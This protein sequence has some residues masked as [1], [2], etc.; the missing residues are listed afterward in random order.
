MS[1]L[2]VVIAALLLGA[3]PAG[4]QQQPASPHGVLPAGLDCGACHAAS[5]WTP[6]RRPLAFDHARQASFPLEGRHADLECRGCHPGLKFDESAIAEGNCAA[7][8]VDVHRGNLSTDCEQCHTPTSFRDV[9]GVTLHARTSFPLTGA[10]LQVSCESCHRD[11]R[12]GAFAALDTDCLACH[13][14]E[15]RTAQPVDHAAAGFSTNCSECHTTLAFAQVTGFDHV[16]ASGGFELQGAHAVIRCT[17]CHSPDL[18]L[19]VAAVPPGECIACHQ[20]EFDREHAGTGFPTA[21]LSCHTTLSWSGAA[22]ADHEALFPISRGPHSGR[23]CSQCHN[24]P[25]SFQAFSCF[26]CHLQ[27]RMDRAHSEVSGYVYES[28]ACYACHPNG[29]K[30]DR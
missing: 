24:V 30:D 26:A 16:G 21:C 28:T 18:G 6:A 2:R 14:R 13:E 29:R 25:G 22:F 12:G 3:G 19:V 17:S 23:E 4:A 1:P 15:Y 5:G 10:H 11:D 9:P 7:C 20:A 8:H 27:D